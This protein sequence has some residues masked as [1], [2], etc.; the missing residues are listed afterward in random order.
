M[1]SALPRA[2]LQYASMQIA[3]WEP[4]LKPF[5]AVLSIHPDIPQRFAGNKTSLP[6]SCQKDPSRSQ[7]GPQQD[8]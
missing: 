1:V 4:L 6:G 8:S 2:S 3:G 5:K 7:K